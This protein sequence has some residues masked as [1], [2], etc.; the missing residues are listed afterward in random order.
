[1]AD[2]FSMSE[3]EHELEKRAQEFIGSCTSKAGASLLKMQSEAANTNAVLPDLEEKAKK[4]EK[5]DFIKDCKR[6]LVLSSEEPW[7]TL[8]EI[9]ERLHL[10][11][12]RFQ[13][14]LKYLT[15][16]GFV[17]RHKYPRS[18][19]GGSPSVLEVTDGG[20][21]FLKMFGIAY[22]PFHGR[23]GFDH[24]LGIKL[25]KMSFKDAVQIYTDQ[26]V[27]DK[28]YDLTVVLKDRV[29][30]VEVICSGAP[31]HNTEALERGAA[32]QGVAELW[33]VFLEKELKEKVRTILE[34]RGE[35]ARKIQWKLI[36]DFFPKT[37]N[38]RS[39]S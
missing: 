20:R 24:T 34:A 26:Q 30:G 39:T 21:A 36:G 33:A 19:K 2:C 17:A 18:T 37:A 13:Q 38:T 35:I 16:K 3:F 29:I 28:A 25:V 1:M 23:G 5:I 22:E 27:G 4:Q 32:Q 6:V 15:I 12:N 7:N 10:T 11:T 14:C 8:S 31:E 9:S